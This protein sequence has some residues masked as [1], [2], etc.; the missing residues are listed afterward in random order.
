MPSVV[1]DRILTPWAMEKPHAI[2][3]ALSETTIDLADFDG[4]VLK[5]IQ[6]SYKN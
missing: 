4:H 3:D 1:A 2:R 6:Y 5:F